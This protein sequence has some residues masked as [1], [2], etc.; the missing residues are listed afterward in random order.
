MEQP[1]GHSRE[2][3]LYTLSYM[4]QLYQNQYSTIVSEINRDIQYLN[5]LGALKK[6]LEGVELVMG[7]DVLVNL[8][9]NAYMNSRAE[10]LD[11]V[12]IDIG[13]G[14]VVEKSVDDATL[15]VDAR[16]ERSTK[17]FN[18]LV[19]SRN[20]LRDAIVEVARRIDTLNRT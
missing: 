13:A 5:E 2:E 3:E 16:V 8:G 7:R 15:F 12:L 20:E 9:A 14:Y 18:S 1:P 17:M 4:Q 19:K 10:K 11:S 6:T